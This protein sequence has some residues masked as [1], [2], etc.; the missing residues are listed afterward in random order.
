MTTIRATGELRSWRFNGD[1]MIYEGEI[2]N[3]QREYPQPN[4]SRYEIPVIKI[5][6]VRQYSDYHV[7][8]THGGELFICYLIYSLPEI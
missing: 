7:I 2:Y 1:R 5:K 3:D 4:G 8:E 6:E